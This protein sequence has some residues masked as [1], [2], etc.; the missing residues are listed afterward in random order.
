LHL[1][2]GR[3]R[4]RVK[5]GKREREREK[6]RNGGWL[7]TAKPALWSSECASMERFMLLAQMRAYRRRLLRP[8]SSA[9][10]PSSSSWL[11]ACD[12]KEAAMAKAPA[13]EEEEEES[14][15]QYLVERR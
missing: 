8:R 6:K 13:G 1:Q 5:G 15:S 4:S 10:S 3:W 12:A 2:S 7:R 11:P 9:S 14:R